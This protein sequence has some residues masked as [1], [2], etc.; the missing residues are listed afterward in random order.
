MRVCYNAQSFTKEIYMKK[1]I[2][3]ILVYSFFGTVSFSLAQEETILPKNAEVAAALSVNVLNVEVPL[4]TVEDSG[5]ETVTFGIQHVPLQSI[6]DQVRKLMGSAHGEVIVNEQSRQ[7]EVS[8]PTE[9]LVKIKSLI[10]T[11]DKEREIVIDVKLVQIDLNE[12]H[13]PGINW[14][15]IFSDYKSFTVSEDKRQFSV[16]T[17]SNE[18]LTVLLEALDTV[19]ETKIFPLKVVKISSGADADLRLKAFDRNIAVT[20]ESVTVGSVDVSPKQDRYTARLMISFVVNVD[21]TVDF[22]I[23]STDGTVIDVHVKSDAVAVIGGIFTQSKSEST[24]KF[25][26]LGDLPLVGAVFRDQSKVVHRLENIIFL[27]PR[28]NTPSANNVLSD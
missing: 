1:I 2:T 22:R 14:P 11:L 27:T 7:L 20:M 9:M 24:K 23:P 12:E 26:F 15:A 8:A 19:G 3:F 18:D 6:A 28:V 25:P 10:S 21:N 16:G 17:V 4:P 13:L 5:L